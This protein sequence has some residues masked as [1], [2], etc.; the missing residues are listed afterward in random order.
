MF[1]KLRSCFTRETLSHAV[2]L[3]IA[4]AFYLFISNFG[5]VVAALKVVRKVLAP[6]IYAFA[7]AFV[8]HK[9]EQML[10][11]KLFKGLKGKAKKSASVFTVFILFFALLFT[12]ITLMLPQV[13]QSLATVADVVP[14]FITRIYN[15]VLR[16]LNDYHFSQ[17]LT[18]QLTTLW[19]NYGSK[20]SEFLM[21]SI[22]GLYNFSKSIGSGI[23]TTLMVLVI[24]LYMLMD[25][26]RL[27]LQVKK[28]LYAY[29]SKEAADKCVDIAHRSEKIFSDF[30]IGKIID[31]TIIGVLTFIGMQFIYREYA[32][33]IAVIIGVTNMI[34]FFGP[35][36]GAIPSMLILIM[37]K[38]L[39]AVL[40]AV[41]ILV[42]QQIDGNIIGPKILGDSLGLSA[43]W[44][45]V[46]IVI[47]NGMFGFV[48][49]IIGVPTFAVIYNLLSEDIAKNLKN[50]RI[51]V[52]KENNTIEFK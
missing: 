12:L 20:I 8:L 2:S 10:E 17:N 49:M 4:I 25:K 6:F 42:L 9:P 16:R 35:F 22:A 44:I 3:C 50:K 19:E 30:I 46:A 26:D 51:A 14:G 31:S 43:L 32:M 1:R 24:T 28:A 33:L 18:T 52:D 21:G 41:F 36:I 13:G 47:G 7:L 40:F 37:S 45:L 38:P 5:Q 27:K 29:C 48:G 11:E 15:L 39:A 34:P 23:T